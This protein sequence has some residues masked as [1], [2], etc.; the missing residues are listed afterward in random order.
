MHGGLVQP[1]LLHSP[2]L[3]GR[4]KA[5]RSSLHAQ[6]LALVCS[7]VQ[8][9]RCLGHVPVH[10]L[11][12]VDNLLP[13]LCVSIFF[14]N[15]HKKKE[16]T[17]LAIKYY[18]AFVSELEALSG[19]FTLRPRHLES[20]LESLTLLSERSCSRILIQVGG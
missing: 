12:Q 6:H 17:K 4:I 2:V 16:I 10:R 14:K 13:T 18:K 1:E 3:P 19:L 8:R 15:K 11:L 20:I 9:R 7:L 5:L